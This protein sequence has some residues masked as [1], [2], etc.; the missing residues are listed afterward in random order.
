MIVGV[1]YYPEHWPEDRWPT[2]A[3]LMAAAGIRVVRLAEFAW[4]RLEPR[5][6]VF[7]FGWL[8]RALDV[9]AAQ[10]IQAVLGTPTAAPP[11]WLVDQHP[12]ILPVD[13]RRQ[14][15]G[16][17]A[18]L[19][20]CLGNLTFRRYARAVT[21]AMA[22]HYGGHP[23]VMGWQTDNELTAN[24]CYCDGCAEAFRDW[25]KERYDTLEGL[26]E[27]W[28]TVFWS[29]EYT[30]WSQIPLPWHTACGPMAHNPSL[31]LDFRRFASEATVEFQRE[32]IALLREHCPDHFVTHNLMGLHDSV[33]YYA[34][35]ADLDFVAWDN[36]PASSAAL[37]HD[38]MRG[39]QRQNF[40]VLEEKCGHTGW[41]QMSP[42]PRPGQLRAWAWEA[43]GHGADA[44]VFF[45]WRSCRSG[46]EQFWQGILNH[47]GQ[48][49]R[50]YQEVQRFAAELDAFAPHLDG[51]Q[52]RNQVALLNSYEQAWALQ[53]QPN[54]PGFGYRPLLERYHEGFRRNGVGV[55]V[56]STEADLDGYRLVVCPPLYLLDDALADR[57]EAY[58]AR[59][60]TLVLSARTAVKDERNLARAE[61]LPGPLARVAGATVTEYDALGEG[62]NAIELTRGERF[63][64]STWCDVLHPDGAQVIGRYVNDFYRGEAAIT[65][66]RFEQGEAYYVGTVAEPRFY[67]HFLR[68]IVDDLGID[69][70]DGLPQGVEV[71]SRTGEAGT[72]LVLTNLTDAQQQVELPHACEDIAARAILTEPIALDPFGVRILR[73]KG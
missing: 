60:G 38:V 30:A 51:T 29:Q 35:A 45:R 63:K 14:V 73:T 15:R 16:F 5:E 11:A 72:L 55:D 20:R 18:R 40:W 24:R 13:D 8:D 67:R 12:E 26:N 57:L 48:P 64:V 71:A 21:E 49:G 7:Q 66:H 53:I 36:Y 31:L 43:V 19:H 47:D 9:L 1:D 70:I 56:V 37:P 4:S 65:Y 54:A 34:L 69:R 61:P 42:I 52:P 59:G 3:E 22:R 39:I 28:G 17:G 50:R 62:Q 6:G 23:A 27:A 2:D 25:L 41:Q 68:E 32:Q 44:I 58:V 10:G 33:D 46:T